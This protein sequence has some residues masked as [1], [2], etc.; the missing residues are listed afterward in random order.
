[1]WIIYLFVIGNQLHFEF[2]YGVTIEHD[3]DPKHHDNYEIGKR[4]PD[5]EIHR[6]LPHH[7]YHLIM[8]GE[9]LHIEWC[10][11]MGGHILLSIFNSLISPA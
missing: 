6:H 9:T 7:I 11:V 3:Y 4:N 10:V 2:I 1:M 8:S 5:K